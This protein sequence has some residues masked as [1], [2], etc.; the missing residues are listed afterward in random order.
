MKSGCLNTCSSKPDSC[1]N[2]TH[3]SSSRIT[4]LYRI[5]A[6]LDRFYVGE[7]QH[8]KSISQKSSSKRNGNGIGYG[9]G[10]RSRAHPTSSTPTKP[11]ERDLQLHSLFRGIAWILSTSQNEMGLLELMRLSFLDVAIEEFL[12]NDSVTDLSERVEL[13]VAFLTCLESIGKNPQLTKFYTQERE[14]I[15]SSDGLEAIMR[16][17]GQKIKKQGIPGGWENSD[18]AKSTPLLELMD[19]LGRQAGTFCKTAGNAHGGLNPADANV[20]NSVSLCHSI[21][22]VR[23]LLHT[24]ALQSGTAPSISLQIPSSDE[25]TYLLACAQLSYDELPASTSNVFFHFTAEANSPTSVNPRRTITLAKE[26]STM[27]TSLPAGIFIRNIANRPDCIKALIAGPEGTPYF[28]GLFEFDIFATGN[29]PAEPPKV[30][31]LTTANNRVRFN[32][33]LYAYSPT[34]Y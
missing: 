30:H 26:L 2:I 27:A 21:I 4:L 3:C 25:E 12:R 33:N 8:L 17:H 32:P 16:G 11:S 23:Q 28:G 31:F 6:S 1:V 13:S 29:Y 18:N 7:R 5:L 20:I 9:A 24:T 19:K 10:P 14:E 34:I 15:V 22:G